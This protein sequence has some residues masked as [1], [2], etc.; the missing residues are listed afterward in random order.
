MEG[1]ALRS[2]G[3]PPLS[4]EEDQTNRQTRDLAEHHTTAL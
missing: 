4:I 1:Y 2:Q 3:D